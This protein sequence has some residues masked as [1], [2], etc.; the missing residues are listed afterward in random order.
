ML[1]VRRGTGHPPIPGGVTRETG[2]EVLNEEVSFGPYTIA[3][4]VKIEAGVDGASYSIG[5]LAAAIP[6]S[7]LAPV[8]DVN[9]PK[10]I[11][12]LA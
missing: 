7:M 3:T 10:S 4:E 11:S 6:C 8:V 2:G 9:D 1:G 12:T 5:A